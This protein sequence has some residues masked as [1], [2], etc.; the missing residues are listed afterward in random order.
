MERE[1]KQIGCRK[2]HEGKTLPTNWY[3]IK[4]KGG[5][6]LPHKIIYKHIYCIS[7]L[8]TKTVNKVAE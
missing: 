8:T 5:I 6:A 4:S 3:G 7:E 1:L 2:H